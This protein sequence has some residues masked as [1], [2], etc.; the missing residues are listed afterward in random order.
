MAVGTRH[1]LGID[2]ASFAEGRRN[3]LWAFGALLAG[4]AAASG[5][6]TL[7]L[8]RRWGERW[9][10]WGLALAAATWAYH[11]C[12]RGPCATCAT[13]PVPA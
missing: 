9:P 11:L 8:T 1:S 2:D 10:R 4:V 12:R 13:Q 3:G 5:V 7:G 6:R